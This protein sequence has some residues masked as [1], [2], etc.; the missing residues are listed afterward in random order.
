MGYSTEFIG[1]IKVSP[2]LSSEEIIYLKQ[3]HHTR[4][5]QLLKNPYYIG[6][7]EPLDLRNQDED[8]IIKNSHPA[9]GKPG[10]WC[11]WIPTEDGAAV[12]WSGSEKSHDMAEWLV[13]LIT[14]FIGPTPLAST[15]L[16]FF[17]GHDLN[18]EVEAVGE[19]A[20]D[21]WKMVV[22]GSVLTVF[23]G[24]VVYD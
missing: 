14:H 1:E 17:S 3:F 24:R 11:N 4:H 7:S 22:S 21:R 20:D 12:K 6:D 9:S 15:E 10:L 13:Y 19:R 23:Q 18:G 2:A 8:V 16:P 5:T